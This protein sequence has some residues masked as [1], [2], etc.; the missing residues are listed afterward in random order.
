MKIVAVLNQKGG[1]GKSTLATNL[2]RALQ[3]RGHKVLLVDTDSQGTVLDWSAAQEDVEMPAV[4]AID[5]P[6][7][8]KELPKLAASFDY[9]VIDGTSKIGPLTSS[10]VKVADVVLIPVQPSAADLW[11]A[12]DVVEVV[13]S[14]RLLLGVPEAVFVISRQI[15][16]TRLASTVEAALGELELP[17]LK[18]RTTQRVA[19]ADAIGLGL[20]ATD[21]EDEKARQEIN[22]ITDEV[23]ELCRNV[24]AH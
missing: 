17:V 9:V 3:L 4:V 8:E 5:R 11:A 12:A 1:S 18:G 14:R 15:Q 22:T 16:G 7:L 13:K 2:A 6:V 19:Y 24:K 20:A 21:L 23:L 10:A